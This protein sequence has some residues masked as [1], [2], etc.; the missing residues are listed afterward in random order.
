MTGTWKRQRAWHSS[1]FFFFFLKTKTKTK[2]K[3]KTKTNKQK[4]VSLQVRET[5]QTMGY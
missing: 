1:G 2:T 4:T 3:Q 5:G